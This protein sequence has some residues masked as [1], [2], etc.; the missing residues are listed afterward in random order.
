MRSKRVMSELRRKR[1]SARR[2]QLGTTSPVLERK[3]NY[4]VRQGI[5]RVIS[6]IVGFCRVEG[7]EGAAEKVSQLEQQLEE[8]KTKEEEVRIHAP[9]NSHSSP[10]TPCSAQH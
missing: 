1:C 3:K 9:H 6:K 4:L 7:E 10:Q 8:L 5:S 2:R